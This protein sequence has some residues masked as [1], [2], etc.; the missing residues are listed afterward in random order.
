MLNPAPSLKVISEAALMSDYTENEIDAE[1]I[2][3]YP[4][5]RFPPQ[6]Y[7]TIKYPLLANL[8]GGSSS[9]STDYLGMIPTHNE[10]FAG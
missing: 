10:K 7:Y 2:Q 9:Q 6:H 3:T 5:Y 8:A 4:L 1:V